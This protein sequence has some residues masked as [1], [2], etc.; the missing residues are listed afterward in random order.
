VNIGYG[1]VSTADQNTDA[2]QDALLKAGAE[3]VFVENFTGSKAVRPEL[4]KVWQIL[5]PGDSLMI[6]RLDRLGRSIKDLLVIVERLKKLEVELVVIEQDVN[7]TTPEGR[8]FFHMVAAFAEFEHEIM[9]SRTIDGLAAARARGRNGGRPPKLSSEA[10]NQIRR[11][12]EEQTYVKIIATAFG[13]TR[14]TIYRSL[15]RTSAQN[16]PGK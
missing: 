10:D 1:R 11:M 2:Q 16:L 13:V 4:E 7:T 15:E 9:R 6:V 5:R 8:L 14:A 12:Y 3:R